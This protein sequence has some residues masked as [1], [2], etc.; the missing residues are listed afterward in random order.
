MHGG[1]G[2]CVEDGKR[3]ETA[4]DSVGFKNAQFGY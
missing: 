3:E 4:T 2:S 1:C